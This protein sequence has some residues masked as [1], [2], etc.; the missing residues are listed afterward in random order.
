LMKEI[1]VARKALD[2]YLIIPR[3]GC[4]CEGSG[5][6]HSCKEL[7]PFPGF[8]IREPMTAVGMESH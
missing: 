3:S 2:A 4:W 7:R 1:L 5:H 8:R 6:P